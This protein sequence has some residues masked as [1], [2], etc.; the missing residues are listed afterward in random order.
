MLR[1]CEL[2]NKIGTCNAC[3]SIT[4][5]CDDYRD[6]PDSL[7]QEPW[8]R[9]SCRKTVKEIHIIGF[10]EYSFELSIEIGG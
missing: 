10:D 3:I 4:G 8:Y 2:I 5:L 6:G 1:L 7:K 9:E